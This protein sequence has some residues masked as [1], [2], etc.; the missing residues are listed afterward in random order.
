MSRF[1]ATTDQEP[2]DARAR[3][4]ARAMIT[5]AMFLILR[6]MREQPGRHCPFVLYLQMKIVSGVSHVKSLSPPDQNFV[7][8]WGRK[9]HER[10]ESLF[11]LEFV[12][13]NSIIYSNIFIF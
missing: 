11:S 5:R 7:L 10:S 8:F 4:A 6:E 12:S 1:S 13:L 2:A 9:L 3:V